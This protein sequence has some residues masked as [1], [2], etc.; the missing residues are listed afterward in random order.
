MSEP[1][2][3]SGAA[4]LA[5]LSAGAAALARGSDLDQALRDLLGAAVDATGADRAVLFAQDPDRAGL[6]LVIAFGIAD[7]DLSQLATAVSESKHPIATAAATRQK[8]L[9]RAA[10]GGGDSGSFADLPLVV[11]RDGIEEGIGVLSLGWSGGRALDD[12]DQTL[13]T[14]VA[15]LAAVALD[16][17]RLTSTA[18]ERSE[19]FER[20][21]HSDPLTGLANARTLDRVLELEIARASRQGG[22]VSVAVFD[23]DDFAAT[24]ASAGN[25]AG[26]DVLRQVAAVLAESVRL[27]DTIARYGGD[28]FVLVAPGSAGMTVARRVQ[29]GIAALPDVAGE[30]ISVSVGV[31]RFPADGTDAASLIAAATAAGRGARETGRGTIVEAAGTPGT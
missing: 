14:A 11:T 21:A 28:E 10:A 15:D 27:V 29:D 25:A 13:L 17:A 2:G 20:M 4:P 5:V 1:R 18:A 24:N 16:R 26:D 31:A 19:W 3:L 12:G 6:E 22:E 30:R 7:E 23:V 8:T 9:S